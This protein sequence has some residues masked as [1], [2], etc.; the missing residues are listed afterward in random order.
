MDISNLKEGG[1]CVRIVPG[2][3][4]IS[5]HGP[6]QETFMGSEINRKATV[7]DVSFSSFLEASNPG[8]ELGS[9]LEGQGSIEGG[10]ETARPEFVN[11]PKKQNSYSK[12]LPELG[13]MIKDS[14][15]SI[16]EAEKYFSASEENKMDANHGS[17]AKMQ[18]NKKKVLSPS[19]DLYDTHHPIPSP[20][21]SIVAS[22]RS[23][24]PGG[25]TPSASSEVSW[26]S[27]AGLL[28]MAA[29]NSA[30]NLAVNNGKRTSGKWVFG[31]S[32]PCSNKRS[33]DIDDTLTESRRAPS[34]SNSMTSNTLMNSS[35]SSIQ[36][37]YPGLGKR[38]LSRS[39][40][41][42]RAGGFVDTASEISDINSSING[43]TAGMKTFLNSV[44]N[45]QHPSLSKD[46]EPIQALRRNTNGPEEFRTN[47]LEKENGFSF[48]V[49]PVKSEDKPRLSLEVFHSPFASAQD[50]QRPTSNLHRHLILPSSDKPSKSFI[51]DSNSETSK[52]GGNDNG[53]VEQD[54]ESDSSAD[55]F[56]LQ[57]FTTQATSC[58]P[59]RRTDSMDDNS[60]IQSSYP[61]GLG[62]RNPYHFGDTVT[63]SARSSCCEPSDASVDWS[64][65]SGDTMDKASLGNFSL[66][67]EEIKA[68]KKKHASVQNSSLS[69]QRRSS[70]GSF[71]GCANVKAVSVAVPTEYSHTARSNGYQN[72]GSFAGESFRIPREKRVTDMKASSLPKST[73]SNLVISG[74]RSISRTK[75]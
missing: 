17:E 7:R 41:S 19:P 16:F 63:P 69:R 70:A 10:G 55:L 25:A 62:Y 46:R 44:G 39:I 43:G 56:E 64:I 4:G 60:S 37:S 51:L 38:V 26:N 2:P 68:M 32:C 58:Y 8:Q 61:E 5:F 12:R 34:V 29:G 15:I 67:Y 33:V 49:L 1:T 47:S 52:F 54:R 20:A 72:R 50:L 35:L 59:L 31:C 21:S 6:D 3:N 48:S 23:F 28:S 13:R 27:Q 14:E 66:D 40:E 73:H 74:K 53:D 24:R 36:Y 71:M 57:S 18:A 42:Q 65:T 75:H 11:V 30:R 9:P 22:N 45:I